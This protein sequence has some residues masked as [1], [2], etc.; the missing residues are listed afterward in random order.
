MKSDFEHIIA[1]SCA[2]EIAKKKH[3]DCYCPS[4]LTAQRK[5]VFW[6]AKEGSQQQRA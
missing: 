1:P 6:D 5:L 3:H 4:H 2:C